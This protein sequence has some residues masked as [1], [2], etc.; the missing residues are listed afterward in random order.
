MANTLSAYDP[1]FYA[2]EA[3]TALMKALGLAARVYRAYDDEQ[4]SRTKGSTIEIRVPG[5][6][7]A[8]D[9]PSTAQDIVA[10]KTS[11]LLD[12]Q[13]EVKFS[14]TDK[15]LAYASQ[16]IIEE[17]VV[18]AAY[19]LADK[20]DQDLAALVDDIPYFADWT[21][22][23]GIA[24]VTNVGRILFDNKVMVGD[25]ANMHVMVSGVIQKELLDTNFALWQGAGPLGA[26]TQLRGFIGTRYGMNF[27][28]N[29]NV[30]SRTSQTIADV[31]GAFNNG[32]GYPA[33][34]KTAAVDGLTVSLTPA[35]KKGDIMVVTG[36][37]QQYVVA[38]DA[39][40]DAGG[41]IA[42]LTFYGSPNVQGGGLE[43]AVIDNAV[44]TFTPAGGSGATKVNSIAFHRNWAALAMAKLPDFYNGNGV[45]VAT[46]QDP[47]SRLALRARTWTDP[48]NDKYF[49]A[50]DCLYGV[51]T[52]DG[53]KAVRV[54]D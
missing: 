16:T 37:A 17:H 6:F 45:S 11:I 52:L 29:Q 10:S 24:D 35:L 1:I 31:A 49:V 39:N 50:L 2:Q 40:T 20:I 38:A 51:K 44:V 3:L 25:T 41:A 9:G 33:G 23:A 42:A 19:A 36:H 12:K 32:A 5:S 8:L 53:N 13:K 15:E 30:P 7:V 34:T 22:P 47:V 21:S 27:F 48:A 28:A 4:T 26:E 54:R 18:P 46:I 14:V 43:A